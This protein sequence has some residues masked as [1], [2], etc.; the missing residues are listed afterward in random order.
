MVVT[1][2]GTASTSRWDSEKTPTSHGISSIAN[3]LETNERLARPWLM[4]KFYFYKT[5]SFT[6]C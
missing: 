5:V 2:A 3:P 4:W 1:Y 6:D